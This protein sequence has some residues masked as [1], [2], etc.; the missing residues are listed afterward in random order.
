MSLRGTAQQML[1]DLRPDE[2]S[3]DQTV[4][5]ILDQRFDP[6]ERVTAY[7]IELHSRRRK[8][9]ENIPDFGYALRR[10][11]CMVY[12]KDCFDDTLARLAIHPFM[13][14][15]G[16]WELA[17][18]VKWHHKNTLESAIV[19]AVEFEALRHFRLPKI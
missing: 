3:D 14:G 2:I 16:D 8:R 17:S 11:V 7:Q 15:L 13:A 10:L 6:K 5:D 18:H 4:K 9:G 19:C 1:G 12:P